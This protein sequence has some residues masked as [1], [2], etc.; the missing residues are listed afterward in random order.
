[1]PSPIVG[2]PVPDELWKAVRAEL[3][4]PALEQVRRRL[5]ELVED[6]TPVMRQL[7]RVFIDEGTYCQG[8]QFLIANL[9]C[10][11]GFPYRARWRSTWHRDALPTM[12]P[13]S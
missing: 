3:A 12:F 9:R 2:R 1:M 10:T 13:G 6:P 4:L 7:V 8:F 5:A 11:T